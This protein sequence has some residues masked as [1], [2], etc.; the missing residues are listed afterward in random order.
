ML[1]QLAPQPIAKAA[2]E[3]MLK[4]VAARG[5]GTAG[6]ASGPVLIHPGAGAEGKCWA[7]ERFIELASVLQS[8]GRKVDFVLGE[9]ELETWPAERVRKLR[10][11]GNVVTPT[12]LV[13]LM[14]QISR[15][16]SFIGND[17]G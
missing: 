8:S 17:S 2:L 15:A 9:V 4:S 11:T 1:Q 3:Q 12:S 14:D 13:A 6:A 5:L 10:G 7:L 16:S